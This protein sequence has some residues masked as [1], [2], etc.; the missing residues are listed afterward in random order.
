MGYDVLTA[1]D[2]HILDASGNLVIAV[3]V[4]PGQIPGMQPAVLINGG[5]GRFGHL[6][7][8]LHDIVAT[9]YEL[10]VHAVR[11]IL[12]CLRIDNPDFDSRQGPANRVNQYLYRI[13]NT[14]L[15]AA[16]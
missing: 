6:V 4:T 16:R 15:G 11:Q 1:A 2:D 13:V 10:T 3:G 7:I 14:A 5:C 8:T 9:G 12:T